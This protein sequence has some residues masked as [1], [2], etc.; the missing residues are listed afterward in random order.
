LQNSNF[1]FINTLNSTSNSTPLTIFAPINSAFARFNDN[2]AV[3]SLLDSIH[4]SPQHGNITL[5][6]ALVANHV[7]PNTNLNSTLLIETLIKANH[8][9]KLI[10]DFIYA[11]THLETLSGLNVNIQGVVQNGTG[12]SVPPVLLVQNALVVKA[13]AIVAANGVVHLI[14]NVID[15]FADAAGGFYGP[16]KE[17]VQGI[18]TAFG[19]L[20]N[21]AMSV[22]NG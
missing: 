18:E 3:S 9:R 14:S 1:S 2:V 19:P 6:E 16:S 13:N 10:L 8:S 17:V 22:L 12:L 7:I 15:P 4:L 5:L 11:K 21:L 20:V